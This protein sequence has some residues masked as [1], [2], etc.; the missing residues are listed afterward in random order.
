MK[1]AISVISK[2]KVGPEATGN[3]TKEIT[4]K[5]RGK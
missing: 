3:K 4:S 1:W 5:L 2:F